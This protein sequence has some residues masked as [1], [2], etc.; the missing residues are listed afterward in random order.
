MPPLP[1]EEDYD[2]LPYTLPPGPYSSKKPDLSYAALV[3]Q[4]ILSSPMHRL[5]LQEIYDWITIVYP[6]FQR[7]ETTWMNSIRHVLSTTACFRKVVRERAIGRTLWAIWDEDL[8]CFEGG[9]FKKHLCKDM[10][11]RRTKSGS[12][13]RARKRNGSDLNDED[14]E[15][16]ATRKT[17]RP[18]KEKTLQKE[19]GHPSQIPHPYALPYLLPAAQHSLPL[20]PPTRPTP[21]HQPYYTSCIPPVHIP[22][23]MIFPP[24]P[25]GLG[26]GYHNSG[27][28]IYGGGYNSAS[29]TSDITSQTPST[30]TPPDETPSSCI[31]ALTPNRISSPGSPLLVSEASTSS[32]ISGDICKIKA[33]VPVESESDFDDEHVLKLEDDGV[34]DIGDSLQPGIMLLDKM[35][36]EREKD[37][38]VKGRRKIEKGVTKVSLYLLSYRAFAYIRNS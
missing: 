26:Y 4:A 28:I 2:E 11:D 38:K 37:S 19:T 5:T 27:A 22:S 12:G 35:V 25:P 29:G 32:Q 15:P 10:E 20:F 8:P 3:G 17:K 30:F 33:S 23:E 31:P 6:H 7:E 21:H 34:F 16:G 24:L 14:G 18:K 36:E 1:L 13:G 9:V